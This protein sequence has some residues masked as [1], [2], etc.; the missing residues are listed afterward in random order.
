MNIMFWI[1]TGLMLL[2]AIAILVLPLI[3]TRDSGALAYKESNLKIND[4]KINELNLDLKEG[5]IDQAFYA[6]AREELDRELL[7]DIPAESKQ[8]AALHYTG[9]ARRHPVLALIIAVFIPMLSMLLYQ[10]MG[11]HSASDESFLVDQQIEQA[12]PSVE[13]MATK[14]EAHIEKNGGSAQEWMM[15]GR[16]HKYLGR[17]ELAA[18]AFKVALESDTTN[19]QLM[20]E[21][22]EMIAVQN[23][24]VFTPESR[25]LVVKAYA[26]EPDN[27][28]ALWFI[29]VAEYQQENY[30]QAIQHLIKVLPMATEEE[31]MMKSVLAVI[32]DSRKKLI[33][34]GVDMPELE[35]ML[36]VKEN[37]LAVITSSVETAAV[38]LTQ[39]SLTV[40]VDISVEARNNFEP[41][42]LVF[43]YAKAKQGPRMPLAAQRLTLAELPATV[44]LD[45][46]MAMVDG[47]NLSAFDQLE[48]SAR[49]TRSG[50]AITQS[51]DYLGSV[52]VD[53]KSMATE[54][55][56]VIDTVVH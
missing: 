35:T 50:A 13:E 46:S 25:E 48:L 49:V 1:L 12:E 29:G 47:M 14:L 16:A 30:Q 5:R 18:S 10:D 31:D 36:G 11:M 17:Y 7:V 15:L 22:A 23:S 33:A 44:V 53:T 26:L 55:D 20:L 6:L 32:V 42:D 56:I 3:K 19:A 41:D 24:R 9:I 2:A 52:D 38:G 34:A 39:T 45:D 21:A 51:G 37:S 8:T 43:V 4:E 28:N 54:F 27:T 40:K